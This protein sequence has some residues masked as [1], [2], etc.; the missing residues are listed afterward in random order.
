VPIDIANSQRLAP[1]DRRALRALCAR[2]LAEYG[3]RASLSLCFVDDAAMR[4]LNARHLGRDEETDVLAFPLDEAPGPDGCRLLGEIVVSVETA[5][6]E[7]AR[8]RK[9]VESEIALYV[10]HGLLHLLGYDDHTPA[11]RAAMRRAERAALKPQEPPA[12]RPKN[13]RE[14]RMARRDG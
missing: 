3:V 2:V 4:V 10:A 12:A 13:R 6:R 9:P 1:I 11:Q 8:R 14:S 7:A 5:R